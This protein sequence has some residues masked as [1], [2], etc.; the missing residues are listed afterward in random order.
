M[1]V[2]ETGR[3][4]QVVSRLCREINLTLSGNM[5]CALRQ[6]YAAEESETGKDVIALLEKNAE[7]A[8][9]EQLALCQ[10]CGLAVVFVDIGQEV[11]LKGML[12]EEAVNQG[13]R[14]GYKKGYLRKSV[15][16]SPLNRT[17]T[18]DNTPA[19]VHTRIVQGKQ[20][21]ITVAAK[22]GGSENM[23]RVRM[24]S[25][26]DGAKGIIDFVVETVEKAGPNPCPPIVVGVGVGGN[27]EYAPLLA[28][29]ALLRPVGQFHPDSEVAALEKEILHRVN[30]LGI[31]PQGLGGRITALGVALEVYPCHIASLPAAVNIDCHC[32][33]HKSEVISAE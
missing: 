3:V 7:I 32:H 27:F 9:K 26:S 8:G 4:A 18:G 31:G 2:I 33:R 29:R 22:G 11:C 12:L 13:V 24:L 21:K 23:S 6:A 5:L 17:N 28:K 10:D 25:P 30:S 20:L 14:E 1:V 16:K 15:V 19:I